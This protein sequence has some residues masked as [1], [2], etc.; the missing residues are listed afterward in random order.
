MQAVSPIRGRPDYLDHFISLMVVTLDRKQ[1]SSKQSLKF[2]AFS[3]TVQ[4]SILATEQVYTAN[5]DQTG[6]Q[7]CVQSAEAVTGA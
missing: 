5:I 4:F 2:T 7:P 6:V 1:L 3:L